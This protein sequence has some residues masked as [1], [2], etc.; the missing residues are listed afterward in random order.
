MA[1]VVTT[2]VVPAG[3]VTVDGLMVQVGAV[4]VA[5]DGGETWHPRVTVPENPGVVPTE[6]FE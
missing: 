2:A 3:G 6:M 1:F 4:M 5:S